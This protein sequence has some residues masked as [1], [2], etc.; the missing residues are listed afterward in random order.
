[1]AEILQLLLPYPRYRSLITAITGLIKVLRSKKSNGWAASPLPCLGLTLLYDPW[2][3][4]QGYFL[5]RRDWPR[6]GCRLIRAFSRGGLLVH[7]AASCPAPSPQLNARASPEAAHE[8]ES[9]SR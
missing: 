5:V 1:M 8:K 3:S 4:Q 6:C 7:R 2:I 9:V